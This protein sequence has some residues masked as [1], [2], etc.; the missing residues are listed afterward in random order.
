M[1]TK[2]NTKSKSKLLKSKNRKSF[3]NRKSLKNKLQKGGASS[4]PTP[5][6]SEVNIIDILTKQVYEDNKWGDND[7]TEYKGSSGEGSKLWYN[8]KTYIPFIRKFLIENNI[9]SVVDL[10]CGDFLIGEEIYEDMNLNY[11]GYDAYEKLINYHNKKYKPYTEKYRE[12]ENRYNI[13]EGILILN[14]HLKNMTFEFIHSDFTKKPNNLKSADLCIIKDVLQHL[15]NCIIE[16]FMDYITTSHKFKYILLI[17]CCDTT[18]ENT[19]TYRKDIKVG[20]FSSLSASKVPLLKY[21]P[22]VIYSWDTKEVSLI[23]L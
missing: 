9:K 21:T 12:T 1:K 5:S 7:N 17:N 6:C 23:T 3:K 11:T 2:K 20:D 13:K 19:K 16:Q 8:K 22:D 10:G 15:P 4:V 18:P 14:P